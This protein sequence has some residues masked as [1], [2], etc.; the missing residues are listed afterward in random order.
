MP[1][2]DFVVSLRY[3]FLV[4]SIKETADLLFPNYVLSDP[5]QS[6]R[7]S[8]LSPLNLRVDNFNQLIMGRLPGSAG[9]FFAVIFLRSPTLLLTHTLFQRPISA[10][11]R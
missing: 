2:F 8:F 11:I 4:H 3:L 5:S 6:I 9:R 1:S 7:R 10:A